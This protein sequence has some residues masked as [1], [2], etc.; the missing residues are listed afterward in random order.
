M[1]TSKR[2]MPL[3]ALYPILALIQSTIWMV[4]RCTIFECLAYIVQWLLPHSPDS[5]LSLLLH[6]FA[7][8]IYHT[9]GWSWAAGHELDYV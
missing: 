9:L 8:T 6:N 3:L 5:G 4:G 1:R 2:K 7:L